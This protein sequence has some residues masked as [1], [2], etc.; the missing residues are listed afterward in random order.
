MKAKT[1][2]RIR[3]TRV[4]RMLSPR[5]DWRSTRQQY[6]AA[7][8]RTQEISAIFPGSRRF[9]ELVYGSSRTNTPAPFRTAPPPGLSTALVVREEDDLGFF[10]REIGQHLEGGRAA[11]SPSSKLIRMSSTTKGSGSFSGEVAAPG[12][13]GAGRDRAG[14]ACRSSFPPPAPCWP[15]SP[16]TPTRT[17]SSSLSKSAC[18]P[19]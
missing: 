13:R 3:R 10:A 19:R 7:A 11:I 5:G 2:R 15:S 1:D 8:G 4:Q 16:R 9:L 14:R 17:G 12:W 18:R 6:R